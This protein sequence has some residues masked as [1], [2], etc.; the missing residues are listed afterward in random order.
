[1]TT[2]DTAPVAQG[3]EEEKMSSPAVAMRD[4][5]DKLTRFWFGNLEWVRLAEEARGY[6]GALGGVLTLKPATVSEGEEQGL[7]VTSEGTP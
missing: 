2:D 1:M 6:I 5:I 7:A 3:G 4:Y